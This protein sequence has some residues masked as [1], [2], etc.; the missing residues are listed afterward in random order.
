MSEGV[1]L[2]MKILRLG[3]RGPQVQLL[4]LALERAGFAAGGTDGAFGRRTQD[5]LRRFQLSRRLTPDGVAGA[6]THAALEPFYTGFLRKRLAEGDTFYRLARRYGTSVRAI[7]AANPG[8]AAENL[9]PGAEVVVPL[10]FPVVPTGIAWCSAL[11]A[12]CCRGLAARYPCLAVSEIGRSELDRP[13]WLLRLGAGEGRAFFNAAHHANEWIT[14]PLLLRF[15]EELAEAAVRGAAIGGFDAGALLQ[16]AE[17]AVAPC[18]DPDGMDLVTGDIAA[19]PVFDAARAI[20]AAFPD[21]PFPDGWKANI[22]GVDLNL[23]YPAGWETAREIKFAQGFTKPAP[24]DYVGTAP[25]AAPESRAVADFTRSFDPAL[26]LSYHTQG[27]VI[28]W[29]FLDIEPNGARALAERFAA[30]S[31]YAVEDTPYASGFAGYKDWFLLDY[32][33]PG[34]TIEAGL[35]ENPLPLSDF[36]SIYAKNLGILTTALAAAGGM[37]D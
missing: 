24:R 21:I 17:L 1:F 29:K 23:Q 30:A 28:F 32:D 33:R 5:A 10:G 12:L 20:A 16:N 6:R 18:V 7:A 27:E 2:K 11:T 35:G 9:Q 8:A 36:A 34:Y 13:L 15:V 26:T 3:S 25:L 19:G 22:L 14:V 31:G 4:Q 37:L